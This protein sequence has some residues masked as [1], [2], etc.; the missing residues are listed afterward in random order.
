MELD[1]LDV[2][3]RSLVMISMLVVRFMMI[4]LDEKVLL[5]ISV[6]DNSATLN[7]KVG[8]VWFCDI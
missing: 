8:F 7:L 2:P 3:V 5:L 4:A 6:I 1:G